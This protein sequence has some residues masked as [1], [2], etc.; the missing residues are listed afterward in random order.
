[1]SICENG[2]FYY[3][4]I[5][6]FQE[7]G[8]S[9]VVCPYIILSDNTVTLGSL[10]SQNIA[11]QYLSIPIFLANLKYYLKCTVTNCFLTKTWR[12]LNIPPNVGIDL[13][14]K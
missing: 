7:G 2:P 13:N 11:E 12:I 8:V 9:S 4:Q 3:F 5:D 6:I 10:F 1:M 14:I